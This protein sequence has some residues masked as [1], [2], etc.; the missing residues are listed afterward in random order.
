MTI[1]VISLAQATEAVAGLD[2]FDIVRTA[3]IAHSDK[4]TT[5]PA[6][7]HLTFPDV[8]GDSHIKA[9][10]IN[11]ARDFAVKVASGFYRNFHRGLPSNQGLMCVFDATTGEVR[12][13]LDDG[14]QLTAWRTAAA[15]ALI[16]HAL[17]SR[18]AQTLGVFGAGEQ[19]RLQVEWLTRLRPISGVMV[20][21]RAPDRVASLCRWFAEQGID[22]RPA[23]SAETADAQIV[24]TTTAATAPLFAAGDIRPGVHVT[25]IGADM[26]HKHELPSELFG[27]ADIIVTDDHEQC[28]HHG[29][30]GHA[31]RTGAARPDADISIG[32]ALTATQRHSPAD[33]TIADLTGVGAVDAALA[34]AVTQAVLARQV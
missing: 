18:D 25:G 15:G 6:P 2:I 31:V 30:F 9:G 8:E 17:A 20:H 33:I 5:V 16:T 13:V 12:A 28:L 1:R 34:S 14:G 26:P 23:S 4:L 7:V 22:T 29:D 27:R 3:L 10:Y 19:A 24:I 21:G 32:S 11:G